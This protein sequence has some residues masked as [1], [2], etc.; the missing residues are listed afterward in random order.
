MALPQARADG[1]EELPLAGAVEE[2]ELPRAG[3]G[4]D[5]GEERRRAGAEADE[6][7]ELLEHRSLSLVGS[8]V[9]FIGSYLVL[10]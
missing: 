6:E 2:E 7:E 9:K 8:S 4:A 3:A 1:E 10:A 5:E